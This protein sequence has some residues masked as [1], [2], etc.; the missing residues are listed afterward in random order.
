MHEH[1][2]CDITPRKSSRRTRLEDREIDLCNCWQINYGQA[3]SGLKWKLNQPDI[4][5]R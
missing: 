2:I 5:T 4:V 3:L 1:V